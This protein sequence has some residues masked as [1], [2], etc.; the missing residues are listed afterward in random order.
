MGDQAG[1][2][3]QADEFE[4]AR[5]QGGP[6]GPARTAAHVQHAA[7]RRPA[8]RETVQPGD[9][10][11]VALVPAQRVAPVANPICGLVLIEADDSIRGRMGH[12]ARKA[13]RSP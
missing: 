6:D 11:P 8:G 3:L 13:S 10:V 5:Q 1:R 4:T 9:L 7:A 12:L 2:G